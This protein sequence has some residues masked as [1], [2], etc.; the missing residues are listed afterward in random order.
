MGFG[1]VYSVLPTPFSSSGD[2]DLESLK[3]AIDLFIADEELTGRGL[4]PRILTEFMRTVVFADPGTTAC[5]AAPDV[6]N[7]ASLRAFEK[8]GF[9]PVRRIDGENGPELLLQAERENVLR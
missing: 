1:G 4:G 8:A 2:V 7:A 3:R 6:A 5:V 9:E